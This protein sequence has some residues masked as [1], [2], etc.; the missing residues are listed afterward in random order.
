MDLF[1]KFFA[2]VL[3]GPVAVTRTYQNLTQPEPFDFSKA[4]E[5][6]IVI[7]GSGMVGLTTAYYLSQ[8]PKNHIVILEKENKPY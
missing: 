2:F 4:G 3:S 5:K 8:N 1:G 7:V 6:K